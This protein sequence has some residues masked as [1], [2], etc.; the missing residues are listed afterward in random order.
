MNIHFKSTEICSA[1][2]CMTTNEDGRPPC[3]PLSP[4]Q[5]LALAFLSFHSTFSTPRCQPLNY[6][7]KKV[8]FRKFHSKP[9]GISIEIATVKVTGCGIAL[10]HTILITSK[11]H[12]CVYTCLHKAWWLLMLYK[13]FYKFSQFVY[14]PRNTSLKQIKFQTQFFLLNRKRCKE[15][16]KC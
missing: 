14:F 3:L 6:D 12:S 16:R 8:L 1:L 13:N 15:T 11:M 10:S 5:A 7:G 2:K 4:S 9:K